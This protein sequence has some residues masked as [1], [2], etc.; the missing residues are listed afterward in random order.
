MSSKLTELTE[1]S[2]SVPPSS[3]LCGSDIPSQLLSPWSMASSRNFDPSQTYDGYEEVEVLDLS[4]TQC[5]AKGKDI[6]QHFNPRY[7]KCHFCFVGKKACFCPGL[8][9]S[10]I[11][12]YSP[13]QISRQS[14][15]IDFTS[16][17]LGHI[18]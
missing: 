10:K 9:A 8:L 14:L 16:H 12:R 2:P 7:S 13:G 1:S 5:L 6:F 11:R 3:V 17:R 15:A 18:T 4:F